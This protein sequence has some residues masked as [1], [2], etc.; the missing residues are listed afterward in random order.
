MSLLNIIGGDSATPTFGHL[1]GY[2][3]E[4]F[5]DVT[6]TVS[7]VATGSAARTFRLHRNVLAG[8]LQL[9]DVFVTD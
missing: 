4:R 1:S 2:L 9:S 6:V 3:D 7:N 5:S 8:E